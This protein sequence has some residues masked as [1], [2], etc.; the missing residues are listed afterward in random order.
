MINESR[1]KFSS[2]S[3]SVFSL[4]SLASLAFLTGCSEPEPQ[5]SSGGAAAKEAELTEPVK[6][7]SGT[8]RLVDLPVE[9]MTAYEVIVVEN[10]E[11]EARQRIHRQRE[12]LEFKLNGATP[13]QVLDA[14]HGMGAKD[15]TALQAEFQELRKR[16]P[17]VLV[18]ELSAPSQ[19]GR[20]LKFSSDA[21]MHE[22]YKYL[23]DAITFDNLERAL[24]FIA[25]KIKKDRSGLEGYAE[26]GQGD[27]SN[28]ATVT[29][30]WL[31][32]V[33]VHLNQYLAW[34][35]RVV[36]VKNAYIDALA[37]ASTEPEVPQEW[38]GYTAYYK[39][40]LLIDVLQHSL[41]TAMVGPEGHFNVEGQGEL[42]VRIEYGLDSTYFIISEEESR[43]VVEDIK[44][45]L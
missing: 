24:A 6:M 17:E 33:A 32:D 10:L 12:L 39:D 40:I 43:V 44:V 28:Q 16:Y 36:T 31:A 14:A 21:T 4:A 5:V 45:N 3:S 15:Y 1:Y 35:N 18:Q 8:V 7:T 22:D 38:A 30:D 29:A 9:G 37:Q 25:E 41:G 19:N 27:A 2:W 34:G 13:T 42:L 11:P 20:V 26:D 23:F